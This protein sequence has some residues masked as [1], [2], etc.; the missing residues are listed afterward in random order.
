MWQLSLTI[1][2]YQSIPMDA[3]GVD[4]EEEVFDMKPTGEK[5]W[6]VERL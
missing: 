6:N 4:E 3:G 5:I 2:L 1:F